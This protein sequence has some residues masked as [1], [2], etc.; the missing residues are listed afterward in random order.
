[1]ESTARN[2]N[3]FTDFGFKKLFGEE[4]SK[5][6]LLDFINAVLEPETGPVASLEFSRNEH[7]GTG[8]LD[9]KVVFDI[10]CVAESGERFIVEM[11]KAFQLNLRDR[12]LYYATFPLQEQGKRGDWD[13][14]LK[15]VYC[16]SILD[17]VLDKLQDRYLHRVGLLDRETGAEFSDKLRFVYVEV[18]K[19]AKNE[20]ELET[21][22]DKWLYVLKHLEYL[23]RVPVRIRE[24]IFEKVMDIATLINLEKKD[25]KAYEQSLK[26]YRDLK[27]ALD[28]SKL[29]GEKLG[30]EKGEQK[31]MR[32]GVINLYKEKIP[33]SVIAKAMELE[34]TR[35][36]DILRGEGLL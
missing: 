21:K 22:F 2:I 25:R 27:N 4:A 24:K 20:S 15:A 10:Y 29:E 12:S 14:G 17:F 7:L 23:E 26:Q 32:S 16:I 5:D 18:P 6:L 34:V 8:K 11:Q 13:F 35:V 36:E 31:K 1:M 30:I 9:R 19:F 33:I 3:P 28:A